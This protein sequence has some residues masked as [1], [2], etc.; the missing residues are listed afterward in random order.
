VAWRTAASR[1][2]GNAAGARDRAPA[3]HITDMSNSRR[4]G[5]TA[6]QPTDD[7]FFDLFGRLRA[8]RRIP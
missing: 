3:H 5:F 1:G 8:A 2:A 4:L 7:A 6:C